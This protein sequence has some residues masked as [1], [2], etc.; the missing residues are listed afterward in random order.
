MILKRICM[1]VV[2]ILFCSYPLCANQSKESEAVRAAD[3]WLSLVDAEKYGE[4]WGNTSQYFKNAV[5]V[6]QWE[7]SL[8]SVRKPLGTVLSRKVIEQ[9]YT[10]S[11]PG[12]PDGEYVVIQYE[13]SF[14]NK[15]SSIETV[16][17]SLEKNGVWRVSGYFIK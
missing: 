12:A 4:S 14:K 6:N 17:P 9:K 16:T 3:S 5:T 10:T 8:N 2:L 11:L 13:T 1:V 15:A 7:A